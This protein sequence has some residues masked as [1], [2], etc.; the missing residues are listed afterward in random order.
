[1][2]I[3]G[4]TSEG[5]PRARLQ[6]CFAVE[7]LMIPSIRLLVNGVHLRVEKVEKTVV[8]V[9]KEEKVVAAT[10]SYYSCL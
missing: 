9:E 8:T 5:W 2:P 4:V 1:M 3:R 7:K 10:I 6:Y